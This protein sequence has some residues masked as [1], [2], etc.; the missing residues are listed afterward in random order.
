MHV[1]SRSSA[2]TSAYRS[3]PQVGLTNDRFEHGQS[4]RPESVVE[5]LETGRLLPVDKG[6][7]GRLLD[8]VAFHDPGH[9][10]G[11][12]VSDGRYE[13]PPAAIVADDQMQEQVA[14]RWITP[15]GVR[16]QQLAHQT[17]GTGPHGDRPGGHPAAARAVF[18]RGVGARMRAG[19]RASNRRARH[20]PMRYETGLPSSVI[21]FRT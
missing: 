1:A 2:A 16:L 20:R 3:T 5:L 9:H 17:R 13:R 10:G 14:Q 7:V 12:A 18:H 21:R 4:S 6:E 11:R 15:G 19:L 8:R